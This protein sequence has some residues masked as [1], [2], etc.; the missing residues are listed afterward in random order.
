MLDDNDIIVW[1]TGHQSHCVHI[2]RMSV[3]GSRR[4][5]NIASGPGKEKRKLRR[6]CLLPK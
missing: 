5:A 4:S 1:Q 6:L 2:P 3:V